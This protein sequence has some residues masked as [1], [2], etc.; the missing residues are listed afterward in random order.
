MAVSSNIIFRTI[1][2]KK[3]KKYSSKSRIFFRDFNL[4]QELKKGVTVF[5]KCTLLIIHIQL[6]IL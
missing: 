4:K 3:S 5:L 2:F 1:S 6:E